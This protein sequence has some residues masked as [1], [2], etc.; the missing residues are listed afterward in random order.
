MNNYS[1][2]KVFHF[3]KDLPIFKKDT[4]KQCLIAGNFGAMNTGDEA[5]L[6]GQLIEIKKT[7]NKIKISIISRYPDQISKIHGKKIKAISIKNIYKIFTE[8][9]K[10]QI[11]IVGG[12]GIFCKAYDPLGG[13]IFQLY[14][15]LFLMGIPLLLRKKVY[16]LGV[17]IYKNMHPVN[18]KIAKFMLKLS[19]KVTVRDFHSYNLL[20]SSGIR[21]DLYKDNSYLMPLLSKKGVHKKIFRKISRS[22]KIN[23]GVALRM[24]IITSHR[25][26]LL[27][28]IANYIADN[29]SFNFWFYSLDGHPNRG[30]DYI[31]NKAIMKQL[32]DSN[33]N[34]FMIKN[35][36]HPTLIFSSFKYMDY[37]IAMRLHSMIF[38]ERLG[39]PYDGISYDTKCETFLKSVGKK[40]LQ[41]KKGLKNSLKRKF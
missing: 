5:I 31:T 18:L 2:L 30:N 17:G 13:V 10:S 25:K 8:I 27:R 19:D 38:A 20:K 12:G 33:K 41:I 7:S 40:P 39:V 35:S 26:L 29:P 23:I 37:I 32:G 36:E 1:K 21:G 4:T 6:A 9:F 14:F 15:M 28:E 3:A 22:N 34:V 24:P 11:I 16:V